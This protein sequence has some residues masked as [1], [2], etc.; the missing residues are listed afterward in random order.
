MDDAATRSLEKLEFEAQTPSLTPIRRNKLSFHQ[1][2][3]FVRGTEAGAMQNRTDVGEQNLQ[4][5]I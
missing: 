2:N 4:I 3:V 1:L 5:E